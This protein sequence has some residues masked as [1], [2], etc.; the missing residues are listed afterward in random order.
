MSLMEIAQLL[1]NFG[2]FIGALAVVG[3]LIY[4]A[5]QV[6][7]T[8]AATEAN[9]EA[10]KESRRLAL[11]ETYQ[12]RATLLSDRMAEIA[13]S[14]ILAPLIYKTLRGDFNSLSEEESVRLRLHS[15]G[16][17]NWFDNM[18]YQYQQGFLEEE[19]YESSFKQGVRTNAIAWTHY[20]LL[21]PMR[22]SFQDEVARILEVGSGV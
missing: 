19:F 18:F 17:V 11:S 10:L 16:V 14:G 9:T 3:T 20:D 2:E 1:G 13:D 22:K 21:K 8:K 6:R 5:I 15:F 4:L 12:A 7:H